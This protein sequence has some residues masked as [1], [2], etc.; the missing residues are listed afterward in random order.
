MSDVPTYEV[1]LTDAPD[2]QAKTAIDEGLAAYN[3]QHTDVDDR[4][5]LAVLL[6]DTR[7]G[8]ILGGI[9]GRTSL[10][11]LFIDLVF[12]PEAMR[13]HGLG[14]RLLQMA[15]EEG[16]ARGCVNA[17]LSA[18]GAMRMR[19]IDRVDSYFLLP[20]T[21]SHLSPICSLSSPTLVDAS[22]SLALKA[23]RA[24]AYSASDSSKVV[25]KGHPP[26]LICGAA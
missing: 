17:V 11:L 22:A 13:R 26:E 19:T 12:I 25:M 20:T 18:I 16:R 7:T 2:I 24:A 14:S 15:E 9:L 6:R 5:D 3:V 23:A 4:R 1:I 21:S 8:E 10:G